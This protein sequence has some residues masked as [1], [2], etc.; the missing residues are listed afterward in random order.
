LR[1]KIKREGREE[2]MEREKRKK[3]KICGG[4]TLYTFIL[5]LF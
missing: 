5:L 3:N 2:N 4:A 1:E